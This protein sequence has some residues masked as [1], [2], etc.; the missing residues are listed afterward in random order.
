MRENI[1]SEEPEQPRDGWPEVVSTVLSVVICILGAS[2]AAWAC[3]EALWWA[4]RMGWL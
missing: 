4:V 3:F 1:H 2:V